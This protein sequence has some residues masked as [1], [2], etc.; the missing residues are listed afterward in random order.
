ML[1]RYRN[2]KAFFIKTIGKLNPQSEIT[3][4]KSKWRREQES[5]LHIL[6]DGGFQDRCTTI[7]RSLR[8]A[9]Q[10]KI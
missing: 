4:P 9:Q 7:M 6:T 8:N 5:N 10:I 3:N 2:V 1:W